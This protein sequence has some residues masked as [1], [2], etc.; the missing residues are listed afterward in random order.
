[1]KKLLLLFGLPLLCNCSKEETVTPPPYAA[2]DETWKFG[3][4]T[5]SDAIHDPACDKSDFRGG[6][7]NDDP[8]EADGRSYTYKKKTFY[9]YSWLYVYENAE[10]LCPSPWRV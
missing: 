6:M 1:M 7:I 10:R 5:W 3:N 8:P 4:L 2:S 9:Y